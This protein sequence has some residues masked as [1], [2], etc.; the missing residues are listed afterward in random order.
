MSYAG[1]VALEDFIVYGRTNT[2]RKK[3]LSDKCYETII[4]S[5]CKFHKDLLVGISKVEQVNIKG[6]R[7]LTEETA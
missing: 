1:E 4:F 5:T 7:F 3:I 6:E 2:K